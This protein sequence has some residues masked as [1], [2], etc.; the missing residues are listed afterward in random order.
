MYA[1]SYQRDTAA[2]QAIKNIEDFLAEGGIFKQTQKIQ[3]ENYKQKRNNKQN[4]FLL[5][6][7]QLIETLLLTPMKQNN[8]KRKETSKLLA[9]TN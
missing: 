4:V 8:L 3:F 6:K 9:K 7:R 2:E 5:Q 1:A